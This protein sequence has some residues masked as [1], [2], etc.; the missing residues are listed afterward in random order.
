MIVLAGGPPMHEARAEAP[1]GSS[2][3]TGASLG[4]LHLEEAL[5]IAAARNWDLLS[6]RSDVAAANAAVRSAR[7]HPNPSLSATTS[8]IHL[9]RMG[10]DT[11]LGHD[12]W[13]RGYDTVAQVG[14]PVEWPALRGAR[15]RGA[16]AEADAAR[17]RLADAHR[18]LRAAVVKAYASAALVEANARIDR[19]SAGYLREE[20]RIADE[21]WRTG[22]IS[23]SDRDQI[24]IAASELE[25]KA[26][27]SEFAAKA[28]RI[29]LELLLGLEEPRGETAIADSIEFLAERATTFVPRV[30]PERADLLAARAELTRAE[31]ALRER[32]AERLPELSLVAQFEH[33]PPDRPN[34]VG[35]GLA[36]PL[37]L[38]NRN[39]GEIA[40][41]QA[42]RDQAERDV[43]RIEAGV[44]SDIAQAQAAY[45]ESVTRWTQYRDALR[46]RSDEIRRSVSL[47]YEKGGASL[48]DL[49]AA[50]RNDN[51]IRLEAIQAASDAVTAAAALEAAA[52][53]EQ[54]P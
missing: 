4:F 3:V 49:L 24:E 28:Q 29:A 41:A 43:R 25:L 44:T 12:F 19:Q 22:D 7:E 16:R 5:R 35:A 54:A 40:A 26:R 46:S 8:K 36:L 50:Q 11:S 14:Q 21:R 39:A 32:R 17:A 20:A 53:G 34:T 47:A 13:S 37:P 15:I 10:D 52:G 31:A 18:S 1:P 27:S 23:R 48:V 38:W 45:E 33:A 2:R 6:A 42:A 9:D 51:D 30:A